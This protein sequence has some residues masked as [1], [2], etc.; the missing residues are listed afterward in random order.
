MI[1]TQRNKI[2]SYDIAILALYAEA[3]ERCPDK[4]QQYAKAARC[5]LACKVKHYAGNGW[6]VVGSDGETTYR[7][8]APTH[9][10][11]WTCDCP[12]TRCCYH[13]YAVRMDSKAKEA[14]DA[15]PVRYRAEHNGI[16]GIETLV[17]AGQSLFVPDSGQALFADQRVIER[18]ERIN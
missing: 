6:N 9:G 8:S 18:G 13:I 11:D 10:Y 17:M 5:T 16:H 12:A 7:V 4:R 14:Q 3:V 15:E 2:C 1:L